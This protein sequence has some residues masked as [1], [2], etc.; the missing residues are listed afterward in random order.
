MKGCL[1]ELYRLRKH[2]K[3]EAIING[4]FI[5]SASYLQGVVDGL[6]F[7]IDILENKE[8]YGD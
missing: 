4:N 7:A 5:G 1:R 2:Y 6:E 3:K 8:K